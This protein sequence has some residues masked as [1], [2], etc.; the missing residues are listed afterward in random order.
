MVLEPHTAF[1]CLLL[2]PPDLLALVVVEVSR[3]VSDDLMEQ[4]RDALYTRVAHPVVPCGTVRDG[5]AGA[6]HHDAQQRG[7]SISSFNEIL[8]AE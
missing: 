2:E 1:Q 4:R 8:V 3:H 7:S 5:G 6:I